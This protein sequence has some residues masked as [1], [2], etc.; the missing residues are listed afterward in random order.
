MKSYRLALT[1]GTFVQVITKLSYNEIIAELEQ[2][3]RWKFIK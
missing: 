1:D 3:K 2:T